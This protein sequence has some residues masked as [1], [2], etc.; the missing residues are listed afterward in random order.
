MV[1]HVHQKL[2]ESLAPLRAQMDGEALLLTEDLLK[3]LYPFTRIA[4][5]EKTAED[6][7][8]GVVGFR[9][10]ESDKGAAMVVS[11]AEPKTSFRTEQIEDLRYSQF[12]TQSENVL[13]CQGTKD[14]LGLLTRFCFHVTEMATF[15]AF[16]DSRIAGGPSGGRMQA[17]I[18]EQHLDEYYDDER[19]VSVVVVMDNGFIALSFEEKVEHAVAA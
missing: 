13:Y 5:T 3:K 9:H 16:P 1:S 8:E 15:M 2:I 11:F 12:R 6:T 7:A 18:N 19:Q 10:F 17:F 14:L 4:A